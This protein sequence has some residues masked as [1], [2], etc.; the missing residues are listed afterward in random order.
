MRAEDALQASV[1]QFLDRALPY[2]S[3][4]TATANGAWLGGDKRRRMIQASRLKRTGVKPGT[5]DLIICHD[6]RFL[7]I[8]LKMPGETLT[9]KQMVAEDQIA[10]AGGG[11]AVA[12]S[13]EDVEARLRDWLVPLRASVHG[14]IEGASE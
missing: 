14:S 7:A 8:E 1:V 4:Y 13:L 9:D 3:W 5:P 11:F 12:R 2:T 10:I 6:G